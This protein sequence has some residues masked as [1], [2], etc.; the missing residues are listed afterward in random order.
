[1]ASCP[2]ARPAAC[3]AGRARRSTHNWEALKAKVRDGATP[4]LSWADTFLPAIEDVCGIE[5]DYRETVPDR[6]DLTFDLG[7][8]KPFKYVAP[9][10]KRRH[11]ITHGAEVLAKSSNGDPFFFRHRYGK[12]LVYT[13]GLPMEKTAYAKAGGYAGDAW[14]IWQAVCPVKRL[15][16][17]GSSVVN[18]SEH[19]FADGRIATVVVNNSPEPYSGRPE[20]AAGWKI[21]SVETDDDSDVKWDDGRLEL[22]ANA[23]VLLIMER[24]PS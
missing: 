10:A 8:G 3:A 22:G 14:R 23:A 24:I 12:G 4:Y 2:L 15:F 7:D 18:A 6:L 1:M 20:I 9:V 17:S 19:E 11:F 13:L 5:L 21:A 16:D